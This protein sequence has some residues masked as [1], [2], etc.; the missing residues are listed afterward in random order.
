MA[1]RADVRAMEPTSIG[2][3]RLSVGKFPI[4]TSDDSAQG[5]APLDDGLPVICQSTEH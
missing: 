3:G 1:H 5:S 4:P 2:S